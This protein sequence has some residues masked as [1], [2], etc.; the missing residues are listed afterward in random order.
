M[1][2]ATNILL[3]EDS[4]QAESL[5][6][7]CLIAVLSSV[8]MLLRLIEAY[9]TK[10][11]NKNKKR[12][13]TYRRIIRRRH[14]IQSLYR[15]YGSLFARAYRMNYEG[16]MVLHDKLKQGIQEYITNNNNRTEYSPSSFNQSYCFYIPNGKI[17][18]EIRLAT[19]LRYFAGGSYLDIS[20][21]HGISK[22]DVYRS[23]WAVVHATNI[24]P[25]LQFRFPT[26]SEECKS[27]AYDLTFRSKAGFDNC[28]GCIDGMLLWTEKPFQ[29]HCEK[30]GVDS[31]KF[32][33]GRKGKFGLNMQGVCDARRRFTYISV[34]HPASASDYLAFVTSSLYQKLTEGTGLP[35]GYCLYGD[36]AYVNETYM[37]VPFPNTSS[38][39]K[40]AYNYYQSQVRINIECAF[41]VLTNRWRLL[42]SPLSATIPINRMNAL[43][44]CLCKIHNF[45]IDNGNSTP[46]ERYEHDPLTLMDFVNVNDGDGPRPIGL[47]GGGEHFADVP[48]GRRGANCRS[49]RLASRQLIN[50]DNPSNKTV[51][52]NKMLQHVIARDIHRP[53]PF[54]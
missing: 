24:S 9:L 35:D 53:R 28:V 39:P 20:I 19:A 46:P 54:N 6:D 1:P 40:D 41:G 18:T 52:R 22:T 13:S 48:E 45:C 47:L 11:K 30:V 3:Y 32:Y 37:A 14:T 33:C 38:G 31:G 17:S 23:V 49:L 44:S 26:T 12:D 25:S 36:N 51:P 15:E 10:N 5:G 43:L 16:F 50:H 4:L 7:A 21:S 34:Q 29:K 8:M 42:K 27:T 2:S